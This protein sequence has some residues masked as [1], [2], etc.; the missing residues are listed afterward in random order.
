MKPKVTMREALTDPDLLGDAIPGPSWLPW[1]ALLIA[2]M[3]ERLTNKERECFRQLTGREYEPLQRVEEFWGAIGRRGGKTRSAACLAVYCS[4]LVDYSDVLASGERASIPFIAASKRQAG[5]AFGYCC[6]IVEASPMLASLLTNKTS[7]SLE[8]STRVDLS[9]WSANYRTIRGQS[10]PLAVTDEAAF[11]PVE[12]SALPDVELMTALRPSLAT[13]NGV[14]WVIS[15]VHAK[16]GEV[17]ETW[18]E[19]YGPTGDPLI[20]V[21]KGTSRQF[22]PSL[23]QK[24]VD[25]ALQRD[26]LLARAEFLSEWRTDVSGWLDRTQIEA[27]VDVGV[28]VRPPQP[29][30]R[31]VCAADASSGVKD[32]FTGAVAH[33]ENNIAVLDCLIEIKSPCNPV[34]AA[35]QIAETCK[36][37]GCHQ[38]TSD[39]YAIG[40]AKD[41]FSKNG[42]TLKTSERDRSAI[43]LAALPLFTSG[44]ARLVENDKLVAEFASLERRTSVSG[45]D[46]VTPPKHG[47]HDDLATAAALALVIC[48]ERTPM[49][50]NPE[51]LS[52]SGSAPTRWHTSSRPRTSSRPPVVSC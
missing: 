17:Y 46:T 33:I 23:K 27:A 8:F 21:A 1:R 18:R 35:A 22:N 25:R 44:R 16:R 51:L 5:I 32:S 34:T 42:L 49:K 26:P 43:Y 52:W 47:M 11:L 7:D 6:G 14:L 36:A 38:I 3:G 10:S 37:Y 28:S 50:I 12:N 24:V 48:T 2:A 13:M 19:H 40:F 41:A 4:C 30:V 29:G 20:L 39:K 45:K 15:S 31:Y 9:I